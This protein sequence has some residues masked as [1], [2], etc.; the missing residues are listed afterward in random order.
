MTSWIN[1]NQQDFENEMAISFR[2]VTGKWYDLQLVLNRL[3][4][5]VEEY[6]KVLK[7][8][9]YNKL[10]V[11][12]MNKLMWLNENRAFEAEEMFKG[13]ITDIDESGRLMIST[14]NGI[15]TFSFKEVKFIE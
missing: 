14:K 10:R 12:Y 3:S 2:N 13:S 11:L 5:I 8:G 1:V 9:N 15:R 7:Q 4:E 6:Y